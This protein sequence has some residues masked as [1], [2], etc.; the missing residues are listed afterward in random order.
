MASAI[1]VYVGSG[2][3]TNGKGRIDAYSGK[4]EGRLE[5]QQRVERGQ[6]AS[7]LRLDAR[8]QRLY[9]LDEVDGTVSAYAIAPETGSL[10]L[11]N[12][13][14]TQGHPVWLEL[15][16]AR[17]C[18][19][20]A[21]YTE[22]TVESFSLDESGHIGEAIEYRATGAQAHSIVLD[23]SER[24]AFVPNKGA[25]TVC[26]FA[27][28]AGSGRLRPTAEPVL[29]LAGGPRV[30][31]FHPSLPIACVI[32][33]NASTLASYTYAADT[34][35]LRHVATYS[36]LPDGSRGTSTGGH[37][38][39]GRDGRHIYASNRSENGGSLAIFAVAPDGQL[40]LLGHEPTRGLVPRHFA[41]HPSGNL[42]LVG[43]QESENIASFRVDPQTGLLEL[44]HLQELGVKPFCIAFRVPS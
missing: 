3:W 22:G 25:E 23:P 7:F 32:N 31:A 2:D 39:F 6:L 43:N 18:L 9:A 14:S 21:N 8:Q 26:S 17:R 36:T 33:E 34:G 42:L 27:F 29:P 38:A 30:I 11:L 5:H 10:S 44:A 15:D 13:R 40:R 1:S 19:L 37:V 20:A 12:T 16:R 4:A 35:Q 24:H 41:L 28:D